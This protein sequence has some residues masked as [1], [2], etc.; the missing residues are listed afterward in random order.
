MIST[1]R[2]C[3]VP[4][5]TAG[6]S[7]HH[8]TSDA[9][10]R[11]VVLWYTW[12]RCNHYGLNISCGDLH[13]L[14]RYCVASCRRHSLCRA[15]GISS[16]QSIHH[17]CMFCKAHPPWCS[18]IDTHTP[19]FHRG[20]THFSACTWR[21]HLREVVDSHSLQSRSMFPVGLPASPHS[22]IHIWWLDLMQYNQGHRWNVS[23]VLLGTQ[24]FWC[25]LKCGRWERLGA[26][27]MHSVMKT[28]PHSPTVGETEELQTTS[29]SV[30]KRCFLSRILVCLSP[31][32]A[33]KFTTWTAQW[34]CTTQVTLQH[35]LQ[36]W[37]FQKCSHTAS[38]VHTSYLFSIPSV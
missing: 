1:A 29:W 16:V 22:S 9:L 20:C 21:L 36:Y 15:W 6:G 32:G 30:D 18:T 17:W 12:T 35:C 2:E 28:F 8:H 26:L 25:L 3:D 10:C 23:H 4:R 19:P 24:Y 7:H 37:N 11:Q 34:D 27:H 13:I 5:M 38:F 14:M 33:P 31:Q